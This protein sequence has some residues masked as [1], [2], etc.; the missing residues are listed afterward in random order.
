MC[1]IVVVIVS[2]YYYSYDDVQNFFGI[3]FKLPD[4][5]KVK[6][7]AAAKRHHNKTFQPS[8]P[9]ASGVHKVTPD[10]ELEFENI[11]HSYVDMTT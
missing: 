2:G 8:C 1:F 7:C 10:V 11:C 4:N 6:I 3:S 5:K 9:A